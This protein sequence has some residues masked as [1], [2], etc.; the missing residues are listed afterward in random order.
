M[1][2]LPRLA[3]IG[4][5]ALTGL[6]ASTASAQTSGEVSPR[7]VDGDLYGCQY[8]FATLLNDTTYSRG[9]QVQANGSVSLMINEGSGVR[10]LIWVVKLGIGDIGLQPDEPISSIY[11]TSGYQTNL[12]DAF[13]F[14]QSDTPGFYMAGFFFEEA[15]LAAFTKLAEQ[16]LFTVGYT[17]G[18]GKTGQTFDLALRQDEKNQY[19]DCVGALLEELN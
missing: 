1:T 4:I 15:S 7:F 9:E 8:T 6:F 18:D 19:F 17:I 5:A 13:L 11:L 16:S 14:D 12:D 10:L 2:K 3:A